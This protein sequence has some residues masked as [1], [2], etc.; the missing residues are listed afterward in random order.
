MSDGNYTVTVELDGKSVLRFEGYAQNVS[1]ALYKAM[2][3]RE[4]EYAKELEAMGE[5]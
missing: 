2:D 4:E 3:I 5:G 1:E